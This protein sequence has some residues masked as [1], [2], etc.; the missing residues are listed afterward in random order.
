MVLQVI[1][2]MRYVDLVKVEALLA[3]LFPG[4]AWSVT[5]CLAQMAL[6]RLLVSNETPVAQRESNYRSTTRVD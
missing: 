4:E 6:P 5:V 2:N 3:T 1:P